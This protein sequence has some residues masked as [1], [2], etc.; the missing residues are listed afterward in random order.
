M[1]AET[2]Q[3]LAF[4]LISILAFILLGLFILIISFILAF[5]LKM[6]LDCFKRP[7]IRFP[8]GNRLEKLFWF[9]L[10]LGNPMGA[11]FYYLALKRNDPYYAFFEERTD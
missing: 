2:S 4:I 7:L 11:V 6:L 8:S 10:I 1:E 5:W 9:L 3:Y